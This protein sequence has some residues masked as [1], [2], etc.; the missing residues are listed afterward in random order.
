MANTPAAGGND[1][2]HGG[3]VFV[4]GVCFLGKGC[5]RVRLTKKTPSL[6]RSARPIP[7]GSLHDPEIVGDSGT[8]RR[9]AR[10]LLGS[11]PGDRLDR[12]GIG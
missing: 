2:D 12:T 8:G 5:K 9:V 6:G 10:R 3:D 1:I 4:V 11:N 7:G